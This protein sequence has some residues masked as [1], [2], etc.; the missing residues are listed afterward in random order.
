MT[1]R[2]I[3]DLKCRPEYFQPLWSGE[4]RFELR[5]ADRDYRIGDTMDIREWDPDREQYTGRGVG[6]MKIS[7]IL[8]GPVLGLRAGWVILG[9]TGPKGRWA[10]GW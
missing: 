6:G 5:L 2:S 1:A 7:C 10:G 9:F 3:H 4:K 8:R